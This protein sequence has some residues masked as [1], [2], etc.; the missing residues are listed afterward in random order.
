MKIALI[1]PTGGPDGSQS[2]YDY[3]FYSTF[4]LSKKYIYCRLAIPT[5]AALTPPEHEIRVFD[6]NVEEI[7]Y[8]WGADLVGISVLT[9]FA[10]RAYEIAKRYCAR[11]AKT[12]LGGIH[13]SMLPEEALAHCDS[14]VIGEA[15]DLWPAVLHDAQAGRLKRVYQASRPTDLTCSPVPA[16][17]HLARH[18]YL[19]DI[20]QTTK[21][22]PFQCEF[23]SVHAFDG[24]RIRN[25]TVD[26]VVREIQS[27]QGLGARYKKKQSI[28]FADD[29]IIANK[30]FARELFQALRPLNLNWMC[31]ASMNIAQEEELLTLMRASGCGAIFIG[32]ESLHADTLDQMHKAVNR[33]Y[34]YIDVIKKIQ[35][36]GMLVQA[37][38]ILGSD[39]ED[40]SV[41]DELIGFVRE[42]HLL[43]PVFNILTP[44]PGTKLFERLEAQGRILHKDWSR[45][46]TKHVVFAPA[47]MTPEELLEGYRRVSRDVYS[48]S[49]IIE[50]LTYYWD[51][52][53][54]KEHN[55]VDPVRFKYRL[56]FAIRLCTLLA[57]RNRARSRFIA[58]ILPR[59]FDR[60]VRVSSLLTMMAYND[61]AYSL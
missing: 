8:A 34:D 51:I 22:C 9:M 33:R 13:P 17:T 16:R 10:P 20:V 47:R 43:A 49:A 14:L 41:F 28:F 54:W 37:S 18:R 26:Q 52:D 6:E 4:L 53:F 19:S 44:F 46:D 32:F 45:Y 56:L 31:Q 42:S 2:F 35:A 55:T 12:V 61:S 39:G 7:D 24:Q 11:G 27:I 36:H 5:L 23:C 59:V 38:F 40:A 50:R 30:T 57:S 15:E 60:R 48:F 3:A 58:T 25:K 29:N 21:G 1:I